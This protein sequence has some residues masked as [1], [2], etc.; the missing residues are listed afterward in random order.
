MKLNQSQA[1][2]LAGYLA[3]I[4]KVLVVGA[5]VNFFIPSEVTE[6]I[7]IAV[8]AGGGIVALGFLIF[9]IILIK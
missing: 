2:L 6:P 9:S 4:S 1:R 8:L 3:D 7:S 5:I